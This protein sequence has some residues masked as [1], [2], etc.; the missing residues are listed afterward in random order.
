MKQSMLISGIIKSGMAA[1]I[2]AAVATAQADV[3]SLSPTADTRIGNSIG[4]NQGTLDVLSTYNFNNNQRTLLQFDLSALPTNTTVNSAILVLQR[5]SALHN[6]GDSGK[7]T[8][9]FRLTNSWV[10]TQVTWNNRSTGNPWATAGSDYVGTTGVLNVSPYASNTLNLVDYV[11][12]GI[13][14]LSNNVT[15][16]VAEWVGGVYTNLG[17]AVTGEYLNQLVY[18][19]REASNAALRPALILD[20]TIPEPSAMA[21]LGL[22][23]LLLWRRRCS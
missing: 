7:L 19:S 8:Y 9:V 6:G 2:L 23:G 20:F 22:G 5:D 17:F 18:H 4:S 13:F 1:A 14:A 10:E 11:S 21:L 16:L 12:P 15:T 3:R